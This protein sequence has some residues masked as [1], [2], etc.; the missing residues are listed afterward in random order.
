[1]LSIAQS[2]TS[3]SRIEHLLKQILEQAIAFS[4]A[5]ASTLYQHKNLSSG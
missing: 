2:I 3:E 1:M 4:Q 5:D